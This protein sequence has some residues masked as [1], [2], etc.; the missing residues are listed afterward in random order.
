MLK[1]DKQNDQWRRTFSN[2][3]RAQD[4]S[5]VLDESYIPVTTAEINLF[6]KKQKFLSAVLE[7]K[8]KTAKGK[9]IIRSHENKFDAQ[10]AYAEPYV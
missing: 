10:K 5:D 9:A 6:A 8:V 4:L 7:A 1:D 3:A 2:L